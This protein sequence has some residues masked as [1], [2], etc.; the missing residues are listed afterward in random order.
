MKMNT[1]NLLVS[2]VMLT[3]ILFLV[4]SVGASDFSNVQVTLDGVDAIA[5]PA[6]VSGDVITAKVYFVAD[7]SASNVKVRLAIEG[8][9]ATVTQTTA[10]FDVEVGKTYVKVLTL[11]VPYELQ[12]NVSNDEVLNLRIYGGA[13]SAYENSYDLRVQRTS[14]DAQFMSISTVDNPEA[15]KLLP[16]DIVLKNV[17][18]NK[19]DDVYVTV[20]IPD[21]GIQRSAYFGDILSVENDDKNDFVSGRL[22]LDVPYT[23]KDGTYTL[24]VDAKNGDFQMSK[25][26]QITLRNGLSSD[27]FIS[28]GNLVVI[29]P[30]SQM[31]ILKLVPESTG[32]VTLSEDLVVIPAGASRTVVLDSSGESYKI[33]LFSK[34]GQQ[35]LGTVDVPAYSN[36]SSNAVTALTVILTIVFLVLLAVLVVLITKKPAKSEELGESYY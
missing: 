32:R 12:D 4:A 29:N 27:V 28:N 1:K 25:T 30:T 31:L 19:L 16:V 10:P 24:Q 8:E 36:A 3:G 33:N 17:G 34:D 9:E 5:N 14:F 6:V 11:K 21:L 2:F 18:Y 7:A 20:Q 15:G 13:S 35:L 22:L 26:K 23:A